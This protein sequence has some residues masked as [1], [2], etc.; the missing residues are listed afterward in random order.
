MN[1]N[2]HR[3][4]IVGS[5][6]ENVDLVKYAQKRGIFTIVCD[7]FK[8]G[9]AKKI[10]D[11]SY[12]IP[13]S[14]VNTIAK[15]CIDEHVDG[16]IG[17]FSDT[18][19]QQ[20]TEI[21]AL[22]HL[23]WYATPDM[24]P[25]YREKHIAKELLTKLGIRVPKNKYLKNN[26]TKQDLDGFEFPLIIKPVDGHG[27]KGIYVVHSIDE[28]KQFYDKV[29]SQG[30]FPYIMM[31]EYINSNEHNIMCWVSNGTVYPMGLASRQ[32]NPQ[33][34]NTIQVLNC[35]IYPDINANIILDKAIDVLQKFVNATGQKEGALSMQFFFKNDSV[36]V[37]EIAGRVLAYEHELITYSNGLNVI[38]LM[39]DYVYNPEEVEKKLKVHSLDAEKIYACLYFLGIQNKIIKN[40]DVCIQLSKH[41]HTIESFL[42]YKENEIIDNYGL[43]PYLARYDIVANNL[44]EMYQL[45][46]EFFDTMYVPATDGT[47]CDVRFYREQ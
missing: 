14:D 7:G 6:N 18:I 44:P 20:I 38:E 8:D 34:N 24:L 4:L 13:V 12:D 21:A 43:H 29:I 45:I 28:I 10:A 17:S 39:L 46:D 1:D 2:N 3:L 25:Y 42:Y 16:I 40:M 27:S 19:F 9:E 30:S 23:R 36:I 47:R 5:R 32:R 26:F 11:L 35:I 41:P 15:I 33:T 22:A 37:C 31:E